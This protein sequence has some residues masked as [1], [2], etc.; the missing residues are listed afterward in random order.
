MKIVG[1]FI[2]GLISVLI[3]STAGFAQTEKAAKGKVAVIDTSIWDNKDRGIKKLA[4][5]VQS[6]YFGDG[7]VTQSYKTQLTDFDVQ[8]KELQKEIDSLIAQNKPVNDAYIKL[9]NLNVEFIRTVN[10]RNAELNTKYKS[11]VLPVFE[12]VKK[13]AKEFAELKGY[14]VILDRQEMLFLVGGQLDGEI[15]DITQDFIKFCNDSF[16][17]EKN[18]NK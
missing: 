10:R 3:F 1:F 17:K 15:Y 7:S 14:S 5:A 12:E 18:I 9:R 13:K 11:I 6:L 16:D 8:T 4:E 2:A